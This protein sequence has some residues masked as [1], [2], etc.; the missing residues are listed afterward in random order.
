MNP[1]EYWVSIERWVEDVKKGLEADNYDNV[2]SIKYEDL[3]SNTE[4]TIKSVCKFIGVNFDSCMLEHQK[5]TNV[6]KNLAWNES[7]KAIHANSLR[8]WEKQ[9]HAERLCQIMGNEEVLNLSRTLEY[10]S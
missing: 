2:F 7:A 6:K 10:F 5:H 8:K 4:D 1:D 3:V 9:E